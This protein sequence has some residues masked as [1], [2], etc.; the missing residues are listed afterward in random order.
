MS[1]LPPPPRLIMLLL[2]L[3][4]TV[5]ALFGERALGLGVGEAH[6][7]DNTAEC[8]TH[9]LKDRKERHGFSHEGSGNTRQR[10]RLTE[11]MTIKFQPA[12]N[13][14]SR[15]ACGAHAAR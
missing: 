4:V 13:P 11:R 6:R 14:R 3:W 2:C 8:P 7:S 9:H 10:R 5:A 15:I 1:L 12:K